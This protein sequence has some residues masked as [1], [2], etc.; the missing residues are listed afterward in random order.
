MNRAV[1]T[2]VLKVIHVWI[3]K[4]LVKKRRHSL[5][6][7]EGSTKQVDHHLLS[8][9]LPL[10]FASG[11][12]LYCFEF[13][14]PLIGSL[15]CLHS[16]WFA[17]LKTLVSAKRR[18]S[19]WKGIFVRCLQENWDVLFRTLIFRTLYR[20]LSLFGKISY[21]LLKHC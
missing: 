12:H 4:W 10:F 21:P 8:H 2:W 19:S 5:S 18:T 13:W 16:L 7:S 3:T 20:P 15:G 1:F 9:V 14:W 11:M 17:R 6:Q